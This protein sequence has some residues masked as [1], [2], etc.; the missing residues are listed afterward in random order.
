M[1]SN[2]SHKSG[3]HEAKCAT[4]NRDA[5]RASYGKGDLL[6]FCIC[7]VSSYTLARY[8]QLGY[9]LI[10]WACL[11]ALEFYC[12]RKLFIQHRRPKRSICIVM[13]LFAVLFDA[14]LILGYHIHA[15]NQYSGL[16]DENYITAYSLADL[17]SFLLMLPG[18]IS[19][20]LLPLAFL[21]RDTSSP[22]KVGS[23][24][25][26]SDVS[27]RKILVLALII[28][29]AWIPYLII[30]WPGFIFGDSLLSISQALGYSGYSNHHPVAYTLFLQLCLDISSSFGAGN[31]AGIGLSSII[32]MAIMA[33]VFAYMVEWM[34][35]RFGLPKFWYA[36]LL[37]PYALT[38]YV[39]TYGIALWKDPLFSVAIVVQ[40][41][42]IAD[43]V[44]SQGY[45][46]RHHRSWFPAFI[47]S[48]IILVLFRNNGI[49]VFA[50]TVTVVAILGIHWHRT[51][52]MPWSSIASPVIAACVVTAVYLIFTGP[53][54]SYLN[55]APTETAESVG[56]PLNQMARV[57]ALDGDMTESDR[58]YMD[59]LFPIDEYKNAYRPCCTDMLKWDSR[60]NGDVLDEGL[61]EHWFSMLQRNPRVYFEA[62]ELQTF[63]FWAVNVGNTPG[64][65]SWNITG[66]V[67]RNNGEYAVPTEFDI[68]FGPY[69]TDYMLTQ[70]FPE[71]EWSV[72]ISWILWGLLYLC[73]LLCCSH[74]SS[75]LALA[76]ST[77][78]LL[79][80]LALASPIYYWP[81]YGAA[82]QFLIPLYLLMPHAMMT[83]PNQTEHGLHWK[84]SM[85]EDA[86]GAFDN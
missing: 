42:C 57:A 37:A 5:G 13:C 69:N 79:D 6:L 68:Q 32:Q 20:M 77:L 52:S 9:E 18:L 43:F 67:P 38:T 75:W 26:L 60:F 76:I 70:L 64:I 8:L 78:S 33:T 73:I 19:V 34:V 14:S 47:M 22:R 16:M 56:V 25:I 10:V 44:W 84:R 65:W 27:W 40:T 11:I 30:Y 45:F 24:I 36:L 17:I 55:V 81:R 71:D 82:A 72:P 1:D 41:I 35:V 74:R 31:T 53:I 28:F 39:A 86:E 80:T 85:R 3:R 46:I 58:A 50:A 49:F 83:R 54:Y 15:S 7:A 62:W 51:S 2:P 23:G 21:Y 12:A 63:G 59:A 66:G 4:S 29:G 48:G 61:W